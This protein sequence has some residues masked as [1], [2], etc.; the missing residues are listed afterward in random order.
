MDTCEIRV[1]RHRSFLVVV[2]GSVI[3]FGY[4]SSWQGVDPVNVTP[5][6]IQVAVIVSVPLL[7]A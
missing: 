5:Y 1:E 3:F 4:F 7:G 6:V 2:G